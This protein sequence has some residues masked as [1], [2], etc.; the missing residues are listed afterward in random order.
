MMRFM[1][2]LLAIVL[3]SASVMSMRVTPGAYTSRDTRQPL[4][5]CKV[6]RLYDGDTI[7]C[8]LNANNRIDGQGEHVRLLGIDT[9]EMSY[10]RKNHTGK[11]APMAKEAKSRVQALTLGKTVYLEADKRRFDKYDRRLAYVYLDAQGKQ[12]LNLT[13]IKE[14]LA[15][16]WVIPPNQHYQATM[17]TVERKAQKA[18][19]GIW[20]RLDDEQ[21]RH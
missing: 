9:P 14:G 3:V 8:D 7:G 6:I 11:D 15:R 2:A 18:G 5:S 21:L 12:M 1:F 10:S 4:V 19:I 17:M 20:T 16:V 13:L